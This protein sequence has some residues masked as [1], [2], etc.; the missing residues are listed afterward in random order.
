MELNHNSS[1]MPKGS[2]KTLSKQQ[3]GLIAVAAAIVLL[4]C[5][6]AYQSW[7]ISQLRT[8]NASAAINAGGNSAPSQAD[9]LPAEKAALIDGILQ[10][11]NTL[12][13]A[14]LAELSEQE[15]MQLQLAGAPGMPIGLNAA[16]YAAEEYAGTLEIDSITWTGEPDFDDAFP[17]YDIE[18]HHITKGDFDYE[19]DAFTGEIIRGERD[20]FIPNITIS[21][22]SDITDAVSLPNTQD[23]P[24]AAEVPNGINQVQAKKT[25]L[26]DAGIAEEDTEYCNVKLEYENGRPE[27]YEVEF[28][29]D[30]VEY[31][32]EIDP[33]NGS[34]LKSTKESGYVPPVSP[35]AL[36][37]ADQAAAI[38]CS[39]A[40]VEAENVASM[41]TKL[42]WD[43]N[44]RIYEVEFVYDGT[45]YEY[46]LNAADGT[47][48]KSDQEAATRAQASQ[49]LPSAPPASYTYIDSSAAQKAAL[50]H[51][52]V[53][54]SE[55]KNLKCELDEDHGLSRYEI[56]FNVGKTEYEYEIDAVTGVVL[57]A[58]MD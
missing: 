54:A 42:D 56:E 23:I 26:Y 55:A 7:Q 36:M 24:E 53:S 46:E 13:S 1:D 30:G 19:V 34:I 58:E 16:A 8:A 25:A 17:C 41:K 37:T 45:K 21:P 12:D 47:I 43:D 18:L 27:Y 48:L 40:G 9:A 31:E 49:T 32:Y 14:A 33:Y 57:K 5:G 50:Q 6:F 38:A 15:L 52:G 3:T 11:N 39:A 22:D 20:I 2:K 44:T 51:A 29:A 4:A 10:L 28:Y 35:S